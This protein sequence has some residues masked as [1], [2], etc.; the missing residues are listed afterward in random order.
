MEYTTFIDNKNNKHVAEIIQEIPNHLLQEYLIDDLQDQESGIT[1]CQPIADF[2][3]D[4]IKDTHCILPG[5][6]IL[7]ISV[8]DFGIHSLT[9]LFKDIYHK[10]VSFETTSP[11][12]KDGKLSS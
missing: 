12:Q 2:I 8:P 7:I 11:L 10:W 3:E 9:Y 5:T 4:N 6:N 1:Y